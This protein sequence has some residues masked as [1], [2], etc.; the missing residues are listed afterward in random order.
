MKDFRVVHLLS[1]FKGIPELPTA[2][3]EVNEISVW[4]LFCNTILQLCPASLHIIS[5][6]CL[7]LERTLSCTHPM[8]QL[9]QTQL[10][11]YQSA[12]DCKKL[13]Y[14]CG[15]FG[16]ILSYVRRMDIYLLIHVIRTPWLGP[17]EIP[18]PININNSWLKL[19][20][21]LTK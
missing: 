11:L 8:A 21:N 19:I 3:V 7:I 5:I 10:K 17:N 16:T 9:Q 2:H 1:T 20:N 4:S 12:S 14:G 13:I 18:I 6:Q 15:K